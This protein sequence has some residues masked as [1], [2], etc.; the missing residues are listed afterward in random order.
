MT[1]LD[2]VLLFATGLVAIYLLYRF[3][4]RYSKGKALHDVYYMMGFLVLLISGLL[5]IFL[6]YGILP[7]PAVLTVASLIPL[8]ISM[9]IAEQIQHY[10]HFHDS[11]AEVN[12]DLQ[13]Y[14]AV[15]AADI[16]RVARRYLV[17]E[18]SVTVLVVPKGQ[19]ATP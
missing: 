17:P 2:K 6:G 12:T 5:L 3:W 19:G 16:Q 18:N 4:G 13:K 9:G 8:G 14:L 10:V 7:S 1:L 11:V 15:T